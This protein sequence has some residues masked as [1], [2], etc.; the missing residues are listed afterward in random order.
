MSAG[1][2][3]PRGICQV[4]D[5]E[6]AGRWVKGELILRKHMRACAGTKASGWGPA[7]E[8]SGTGKAAVRRTDP[9]AEVPSE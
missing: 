4:C 1:H 3:R 7:I 2:P 6:I 9:P 8:C 5:R